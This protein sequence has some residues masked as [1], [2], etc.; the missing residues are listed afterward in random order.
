[1]G[2]FPKP[3]LQNLCACSF[4]HGGPVWGVGAPAVLT[5]LETLCGCLVR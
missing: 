2:A 3:R 4:T 5:P 1:M